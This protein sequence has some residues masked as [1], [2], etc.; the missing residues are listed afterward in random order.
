MKRFDWDIDKN[1]KL[2]KERNISF[3]E[4]IVFIEQGKMLDII[5]HPNPKYRHQKMFVLDVEGY[6]YLVPFIETGEAYVLKTIFPSRKATKEY[7]QGGS[8]HEIR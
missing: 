7:L 6:V 3:E 5:D 2:I 4:I 8:K 1:K